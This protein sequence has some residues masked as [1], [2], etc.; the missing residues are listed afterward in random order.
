MIRIK[1]LAAAFLAVI[2]ATLPAAAVIKVTPSDKYVTRVVTCP[3]FNKLVT[4]TS[5]D[6]EYTVG[7]KSVKLYA[8]DNLIDYMQVTSTRKTLSVAWK[9]NGDLLISGRWTAKMIV[10]AP[11]GSVNEFITNSSGDVV[12]KS[13]LTGAVNYS[14][15]TNSSGDIKLGAVDA[16]KADV[17]LI[18]NSS[19]DV[20]ATSVTGG[21][22]TLGSNSSGDVSVISVK[23]SQSASMLANSSGDVKAGKVLSASISVVSTSSGDVKAGNVSAD[24]A[25]VESRSSGDVGRH[26]S[27]RQRTH[28]ADHVG[29]HLRSQGQGVQSHGPDGGSVVVGRSGMLCRKKAGCHL[30][31]HHGRDKLLFKARDG[32]QERCLHRKHQDRPVNLSHA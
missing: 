24:N 12:I 19:G 20:S 17:K 15:I 8:P 4:N 1:P 21:N 23:A 10:S 6:I 25:I 31:K 2:I 26:Y 22:V 28:G 11:A 13:N 7:P 16:S 30:H 3:D 14:F 27:C 29:Q 32:H 5:I 9:N 18:T